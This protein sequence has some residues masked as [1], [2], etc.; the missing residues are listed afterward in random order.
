MDIDF[1]LSPDTQAVLLLCGALGRSDRDLP[2]LT[3][4]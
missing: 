2:P 1:S 4:G 3:P